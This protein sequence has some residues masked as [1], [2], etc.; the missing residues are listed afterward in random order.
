VFSIPKSS[1]EARTKAAKQIA[2]VDNLQPLQRRNSG[3]S[4]AAGEEGRK[5]TFALGGKGPQVYVGAGRFGRGRA[6]EG[7][8]GRAGRAGG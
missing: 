4:S 7:P 1:R 8:V 5:C 3:R 6:R 2:Y